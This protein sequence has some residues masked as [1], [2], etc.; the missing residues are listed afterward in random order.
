MDQADIHEIL[1]G[2]RKGPGVSLMRGVLAV[3]SWPYAG[4]MRLRRG[5]YRAGLLPS[6]NAQ[7]PVVCVGN[8]TTGGTGKTPMVAW[9]VEY[10]QQL[11]RA[12]A[13]LTRGYKA[14]DGVSDEAQLLGQATGAAVVVDPDRLAGASRAVADGADALVMDDGFQHLR[15]RRD[16]N[17]VLIDATRPWGYG[18][19]LPRGI[20]REPIAA[21]RDAEAV[22]ITRADQVGSKAVDDIRRRIREI[23]PDAPIALASHRP[24]GV[25]D[26]SGEHHPL[27]VLAGRKVCAFCGIG[28]PEA[29]F[30]TLESLNAR[31]VSRHALDDHYEYGL[32]LEQITCRTCGEGINCPAQVMITTAKDYVKVARK[33]IGREVWQLTT[34]M[35]I[36][37]G[38]DAIE[39]LLREAVDVQSS[40]ESSAGGA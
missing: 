22:V 40:D 29:F 15:L 37:D 30:R 9:V 18:H 7:V 8:L 24:S 38:A 14:A 6:R 2:R 16:L 32:Q 3:A 31:V 27:D 28:N 21:L 25:I 1:S 13:V 17:I 33:P 20:L 39:R 5:A 10:L 11:G 35:D 12:P 23:V 34:A 19:C 36:H 26:A 4:L